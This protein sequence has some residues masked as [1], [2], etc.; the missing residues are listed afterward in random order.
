[1]SRQPFMRSAVVTLAELLCGPFAGA[2]MAALV[3]GGMAEVSGR[4][5]N[6]SSSDI[7]LNE[8]GGLLQ[9]NYF[10]CCN[11]QDKKCG[12]RLAY[13][14]KEGG[15]WM[16]LDDIRGM[17]SFEGLMLRVRSIDSGIRGDGEPSRIQG[18]SGITLEM[19]LQLSADRVS[20]YD[21]GRGAHL[22]GFKM[23]SSETLGQGRP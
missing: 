11:E 18:Q 23:G 4:G 12:A 1:M 3:E 13:Q 16:V 21:D 6:Y 8:L 7:E 5:G 19:D 9:N 17:F 22:E 15:G 2:E 20:Y 14:L 10:G